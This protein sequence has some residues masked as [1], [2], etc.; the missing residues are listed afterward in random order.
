MFKE[1]LDWLQD[2]LI[3]VGAIDLIQGILGILGFGV[4]LSGLLGTVAIKSGFVVAGVLALLGA[5]LLAC[6]DRFHAR[7]RDQ[8]LRRLLARYC[9]LLKARGDQRWRIVRWEETS[10]VNSNGDAKEHVVVTAVVESELLDFFAIR[11]G[12][13]WDQDPRE[14]CRA[15]FGVTSFAGEGVDSSGWDATYD[16]RPDGRVEAVVH[17]ANPMR[18]GA[19][20]KMTLD[21]EW[22]RK[23]APLMKDRLPDAFA[24]TFA[25]PIDHIE[26]SVVLPCGFEADC[27]AVGLR[28]GVDDYVLGVKALA[29]E[30]VEARLVARD[31][32]EF[33]RVGMVLR[34]KEKRTVLRRVS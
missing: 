30:P 2:H 32:P 5:L 4:L 8:L 28:E 26:Y 15:K 14:R 1:F 12:S 18:R 17:F 19:L 23:C 9:A 7:Y 25:R 13:G 11:S 20:I 33:R 16:W 31:I 22:P 21:K 34:L 27:D 3:R 24:L 29:T 10:L 6:A